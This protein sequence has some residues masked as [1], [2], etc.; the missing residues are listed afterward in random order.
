MLVIMSATDKG[1]KTWIH[2][3]LNELVQVMLLFPIFSIS[4]V[5]KAEGQQKEIN[6]HFHR[7]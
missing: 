3:S 4:I 6:C 2:G 5:I 1:N 7:A